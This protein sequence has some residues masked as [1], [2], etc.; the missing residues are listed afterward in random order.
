MNSNSNNDLQSNG[1][2][3]P[4]TRRAQPLLIAASIGTALCLALGM[5]VAA[6]GSASVVD[7][8]FCVSSSGYEGKFKG[9]RAYKCAGTDVPE[10][11][12]VITACKVDTDMM[13]L[14]RSVDLSWSSNRAEQQ[15][16]SLVSGNGQRYPLDISKVTPVAEGTVF[17]YKT[18]ITKQMAASALG[19]LLAS[20]FTMEV[21]SAKSPSAT[22]IVSWGAMG[23]NPTC[24]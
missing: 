20:G 5:G 6:S 15:R 3:K 9:E 8:G 19:D 14:F 17:S 10:D 11:S 4:R 18:T 1:T 21:A 13:R 23:A 12:V 24:T 2:R 22:R 7:S 16:L